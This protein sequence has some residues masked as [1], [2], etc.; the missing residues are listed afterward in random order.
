[1]THL[2][3]DWPDDVD[4]DMFRRMGES[5]F[6]FSEAVE[7]EFIVDFDSWPPPESFLRAL[8]S[9]YPRIQLHNP[10]EDG[11]GYV[12]FLV[13]GL[14]T[15]ELAMSVQSTVSELAAPFGGVCDS[16]GAMQPPSRT[17][18]WT[19]SADGKWL[20]ASF[21][22]EGFP[23]ALRVR[24]AA[25]SDRNRA[26]FPQLVR[27]THQL[28]SVSDN[29]LPE[30]GYNRSLAGFDQDALDLFEQRDEGLIVL[31][32]TFAGKRTYYGFALASAPA[33]RRLQELKQRYPEHDISVQASADPE[34]QFLSRYKEDFPW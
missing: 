12:I 2:P 34:W 9:L 18:S 33:E 1:M 24:P 22:Y 19:P 32:E 6:D 13:H 29:G 7:I 4:G 10:D 25:D 14:L 28:A 23:L 15:Y 17:G 30:T 26:R 11:D 21:T 3:T 27:I 5:G 31:I 20:G 16:W 8:H